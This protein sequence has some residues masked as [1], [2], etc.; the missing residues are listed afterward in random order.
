M[1]L[2]DA[3]AFIVCAGRNRPLV[4]EADLCVGDWSASFERVEDSRQHDSGLHFEG[5]ANLLIE[6]RS[7]SAVFS[8]CALILRAE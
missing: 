1:H 4:I 6:L 8:K 3:A 5:S 7:Y 2:E